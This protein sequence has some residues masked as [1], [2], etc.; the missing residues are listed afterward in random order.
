M[1]VV[2]IQR[3]Q[4]ST[5][6]RLK[7]IQKMP[8]SVSRNSSCLWMMK[9]LIPASPN[10]LHRPRMTLI[11]PIRPKSEGVNS[12][13]NTRSCVNV[14]NETTVCE[15]A[16]DLTPSIDCCLSVMRTYFSLLEFSRH[17]GVHPCPFFGPIELVE[18]R[19]Y[20]LKSNSHR[21]Q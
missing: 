16:V 10:K 11:I 3:T 8:E 18:D 19:S 1:D 6:A 17:H 21:R 14:S 20:P 13:V 7:L 9:L 5:E 4:Q 15:V 2:A 12:R